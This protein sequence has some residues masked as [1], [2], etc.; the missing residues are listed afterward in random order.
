MTIISIRRDIA[1]RVTESLANTHLIHRSLAQ[2][3]IGAV[4]V[5]E[6]PAVNSIM[7]VCCWGSCV[8]VF[9]HHNVL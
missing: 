3:Q 6:D 9:E 5:F 2:R 4:I 1:S 7:C 8:Y